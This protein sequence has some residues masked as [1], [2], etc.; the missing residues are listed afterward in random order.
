MDLLDLLPPFLL[1]YLWVLCH[2]KSNNSK[3]QNKFFFKNITLSQP[4]SIFSHS[5]WCHAF[6][7]HWLF[8][9]CCPFLQEVLPPAQCPPVSDTTS[10]R[11]C[12]KPQAKHTTLYPFV[13]SFTMHPVIS[14]VITIVCI[15]TFLLLSRAKS[16]VRVLF[17]NSHIWDMTYLVL[18]PFT[19]SAAFTNIHK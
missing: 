19:V 2:P 7:V 6:V 10:V 16:V 9:L 1:V 15:Y 8:L 18:Y 3:I 5:K 14:Q 11:I 17:S 12:Y 13:S 4:K